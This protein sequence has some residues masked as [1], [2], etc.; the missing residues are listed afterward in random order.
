MKKR[1]AG[2]CA[3]AVMKKK[4][5]LYN[6]VMALEYGMIPDGEPDHTPCTTS[7]AS[8]RKVTAVRLRRIIF[9]TGSSDGNSAVLCL[10]TDSVYPENVFRMC[11]NREAFVKKQ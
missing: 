11:L 10:F 8:S 4:K 6:G 2:A 5:M 1:R 7:R 9:Q 3:P